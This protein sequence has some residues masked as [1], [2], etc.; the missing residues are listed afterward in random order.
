MNRVFDIK[1]RVSKEEKE[2]ISEKA[3]TMGLSPA[4]YLRLLGLNSTL[5]VSSGD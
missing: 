3:I 4:A 1:V 2:K 5:R